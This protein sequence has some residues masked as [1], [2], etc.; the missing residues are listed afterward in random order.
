MFFK[1]EFIKGLL[2]GRQQ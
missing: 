2:A 1:D